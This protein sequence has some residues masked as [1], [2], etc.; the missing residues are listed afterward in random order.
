MPN[1]SPGR[2]RFVRLSTALLTVAL[3]ATIVALAIQGRKLAEM[4]RRTNARGIQT[5]NMTAKLNMHINKKFGELDRR[6]RALEAPQQPP[7]P[8]DRGGRKQ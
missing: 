4:E 7:T 1:E 8:G 5:A 2:H 6:I 3:A